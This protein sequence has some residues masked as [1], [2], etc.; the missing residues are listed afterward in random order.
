M[1]LT[2]FSVPSTSVGIFELKWNQ[3]HDYTRMCYSHLQKKTISQPS[4]VNLTSNATTQMLN[5]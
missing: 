3:F 2:N 4:E 5:G 1:E